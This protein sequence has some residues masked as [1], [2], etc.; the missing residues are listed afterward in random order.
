MNAQWVFKL[1]LLL[2]V[3]ICLSGCLSPGKPLIAERSPAYTSGPYSSGDPLSKSYVVQKGDTLYS[4]A[5]RFELDYKGLARANGVRAPYRIVPGQRLSLVTQLTPSAR[6]R[7]PVTRPPAA[8]A[9]QPKPSSQQP[10]TTDPA[11]NVASGEL[12]KAWTWPLGIAPYAEFGRGTRGLNYRLGD[13][14]NRRM[15]VRSTNSGEVVYAGTGLGGFEHLVIVK[16]SASLLSAYSFDG[17]LRV[18]EKQKIKAGGELADIRN[19]G[20]SKQSLHFEL[21]KDG[22]PINPRQFLR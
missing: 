7:T 18:T 1:L 8:P 2:S 16:H 20:R 14:R 15:T 19:R 17:S 12:A 5:W 6:I 9:S 11:G 13:D 4:I 22:Q 3:G 10:A 21:R